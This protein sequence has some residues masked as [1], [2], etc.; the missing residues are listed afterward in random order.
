LMV[1]I[2]LS[3]VLGFISS[4][5]AQEYSNETKMR[6]ENRGS[7]EERLVRRIIPQA[8]ILLSDYK[9]GDAPNYQNKN[10]FSVG[11][12]VD[13]GTDYHFVVE[14]GLLYR[15]LNAGSQFA[16]WNTNYSN[17]YLSLPV[18]AKYYF[19]GQENTSVY[20]KGGAM[21]STLLSQT[22]NSTPGSGGPVYSVNDQNFEVSALGG[23]GAK[24]FITR[25]T[26]FVVEGV[27][28]RDVN[29]IFTNGAGV[30]NSALNL[31]AGVTVNL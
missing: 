23:L 28:T 7:S 25:D 16:L 26:D 1:F 12:L 30:Y 5:Y 6:F 19:Q 29:A 24:F 13:F 31:S 20:I 15:Q 9:G 22:V 11:A 21:G 27:Y 18:A 8:A 10:G 17:N 14:S 3:F 4:A 2:V